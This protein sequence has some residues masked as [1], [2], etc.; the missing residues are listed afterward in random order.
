L[1]WTDA[2]DEFF[3]VIDEFLT[4]PVLKMTG[5]FLHISQ[6]GYDRRFDFE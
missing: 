6:E 3:T 2:A 1:R 4:D 5:V